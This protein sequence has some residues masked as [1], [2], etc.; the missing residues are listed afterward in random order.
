MAGANL[1]FLSMPLM[2]LLLLLLLLLR[3]FPALP[4][5]LRNLPTKGLSS[6][7]KANFFMSRE[8]PEGAISF[9]LCGD[10]FSHTAGIASIP[11][12]MCVGGIA[13]DLPC[14]RFRMKFVEF[15]NNGA[16]AISITR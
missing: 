3:L 8:T 11:G 15:N 9:Y 7:F 6:K 2:L 10:L 4:L 13:G 1:L 16:H 5:L 14:L 12:P